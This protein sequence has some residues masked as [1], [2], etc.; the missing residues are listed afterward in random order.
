M[1]S[2]SKQNAYDP[3]NSYNNQNTHKTMNSYYK[4]NTYDPN[5]S[6]NH[7]RKK[8]KFKLI[9]HG[10]CDSKQ[11]SMNNHEYKEQN[12]PNGRNSNQTKAIKVD[13]SNKNKNQIDFQE[14][15]HNEIFKGEKDKIKG[16]QHNNI[17]K[18][19]KDKIGE[20]G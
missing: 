2:H 11:S 12:T 17:L 13:N 5:N 20:T 9:N 8:Q 19:D 10:R 7:R 6:Y 4:Q 18:G 15:H 3:N 1:N 14:R 16:E